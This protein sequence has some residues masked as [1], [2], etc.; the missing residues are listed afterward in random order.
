MRPVTVS[1]L[2]P[3]SAIIESAEGLEKMQQALWQVVMQ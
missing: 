3:E 1:T 2:A